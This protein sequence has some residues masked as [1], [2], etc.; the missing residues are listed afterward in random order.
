MMQQAS[1][2]VGHIAESEPLI[3]RRCHNKEGVDQF[4]KVDT[5]IINLAIE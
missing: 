3:G 1:N 2:Y 5:L 4:E